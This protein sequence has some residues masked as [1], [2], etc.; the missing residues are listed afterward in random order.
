[1]FVHVTIVL[2]GAEVL[3]S[4]DHISMLKIFLSIDQ[5]LPVYACSLVCS[6]CYAQVPWAPWDVLYP[7][8]FPCIAIGLLLAYLRNK[9]AHR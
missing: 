6:P 9:R 5:Q 7:T 2:H 4:A 8:T 3:S 1:M